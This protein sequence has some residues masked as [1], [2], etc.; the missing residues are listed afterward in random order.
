MKKL[1]FLL[2][3][4]APL[5]MF[6]QET[7]QCDSNYIR[8]FSKIGFDVTGI[9]CERFVVI[10]ERYYD[11]ISQGYNLS[12]GIVY[13]QEKVLDNLQ[14]QLALANQYS[15]TLKAANDSANATI[16][17]F[18]ANNHQYAELLKQSTTENDKLV[19]RMDTL[20]ND[21]NKQHKREVRRARWK[22]FAIGGV[23]GVVVGSVGVLILRDKL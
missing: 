10:G 18:A 9:P 17:R 20:L 3:F 23:I 14:K 7:A 8:I 6:G 5:A 19:N 22:S 11:K 13:G 4:L 1:L 12:R 16:D 21:L 2:L 15:A